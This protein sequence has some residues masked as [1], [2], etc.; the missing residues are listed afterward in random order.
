MRVCRC[1]RVCKCVHVCK[2][3]CVCMIASVSVSMCM[4]INEVIRTDGM[5]R[6]VCKDSTI[7]DRCMHKSFKKHVVPRLLNNRA[8]F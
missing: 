2:S 8:I 6:K 7:R 1:V 3:A 5:T 4:N